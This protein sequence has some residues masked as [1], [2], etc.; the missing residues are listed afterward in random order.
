[1][2]SCADT[3]VSLFASCWRSACLE[4]GNSKNDAQSCGVSSCV[5]AFARPCIYTVL[6][7]HH[8]HGGHVALSGEERKGARKGRKTRTGCRASGLDAMPENP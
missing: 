5:N 7:F 8:S 3:G 1:M 6:Y 2:L 4:A